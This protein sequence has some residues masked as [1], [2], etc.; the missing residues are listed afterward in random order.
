MISLF[1]V[2]TPGPA[3]V[4]SNLRTGAAA[5]AKTQVCAVG[6]YSVGKSP[7][8]GPCAACPT[9][10][11]T[12]GTGSTSIAACTLCSGNLQGYDCRGGVPSLCC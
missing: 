7:G 3:D 5:A 10:S 11:T 1:G 6:K 4:A 2:C 12:A 8:K 9:G